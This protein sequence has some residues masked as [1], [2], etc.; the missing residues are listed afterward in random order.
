MTEVTVI[1]TALIGFAS[2]GMAV[3]MWLGSRL[4][5]VTTDRNRLQ[6]VVDGLR[7]QLGS[8]RKDSDM[9]YRKVADMTLES[10]ELL[11]AAHKSQAAH[12]TTKRQ[13]AAA[14]GQITKLK[15]R[16]GNG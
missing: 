16:I 9:L 13:L 12:A 15:R 10:V 8:E 1:M 5:R 7:E 3:G 14:K 6:A 4:A 2:G 11:D